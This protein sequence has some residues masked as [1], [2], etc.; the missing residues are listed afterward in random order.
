MPASVKIFDDST[1]YCFESL[2]E[3]VLAALS[4]GCKNL[5]LHVDGTY[6][7]WD[8]SVGDLKE[9]CLTWRNSFDAI[10]LILSNKDFD[11]LSDVH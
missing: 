2:S 8:I 7:E 3:E 9:A 6:A 10:S 1:E 11:G 5:R 4:Q